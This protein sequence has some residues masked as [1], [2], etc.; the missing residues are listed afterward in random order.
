MALLI[1]QAIVIKISPKKCIS[2]I[3][4]GREKLRPRHDDC[5][6]TDKKKEHISAYFGTASFTTGNSLPVAPRN[7]KDQQSKASQR[8]FF[9]TGSVAS[10]PFANIKKTLDSPHVR[11]KEIVRPQHQGIALM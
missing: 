5:R 11:D 2:C 1:A 8:F 7:H 4:L 6:N 3:F 10:L 9:D